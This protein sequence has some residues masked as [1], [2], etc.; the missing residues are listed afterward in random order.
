MKDNFEESLAHVLKSEG[1]YVDH[2]KDPGGA[3]N[4]GCT[5]KVWEEWVGHEVTKDD[6]KALTVADVAP[7]YKAKYWDK[8]RCDDLPH[9][10]D[11]ATFDLAIN[12]G[13]ARA[14]K[15]L[16]NAC[17]VVADGAIGPATLAAV[18]KMNPRELA[19][20]ICEDRLAFLQALPTWGT[21]GKGWGRRVA[22]V[23][24][25]AFNMVG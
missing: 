3:T 17:G 22:E 4:L 8:C 7:L 1:G 20:K 5:K 12:S 21:F 13:P 19:S 24:K 6:I 9:G 15:F 23:E 18:A 10:V 25:T 11:F 16:Q 14:S 2:P